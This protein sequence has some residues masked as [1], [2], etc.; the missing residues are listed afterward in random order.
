MTTWKRLAVFVSGAGIVTVFIT[1]GFIATGSV[2]AGQQNRAAAT[3]T[4]LD[5]IQMQQLVA[6]GQY[7]LHTG[8]DEGRLYAQLFTVDGTSGAVTGA[9]ALATYAKGGRPG[10]RSLVTNVIIEATPQGA[11]GRHYEFMIRFVKG[12]D[13]PVALD[14][15]GRYDDDF[16]KTSAG[17]RIKKRVFVPSVF[18]SEASKAIVP[19]APA[20]PAVRRP[21]VPAPMPLTRTP[22]DAF[23]STLT[24]LDYIQIQQL[25]AS[26]GQALDNGLDHEDNGEAYASLFAPGGVF[27]RPYTQGAEALKALARTQPHNRR[28]ARHFLTNI[29]IE[30]SPDGAAGRQYLVVIDQ[31]EGGRPSSALIAGH[32]EDIY[33]K[34]PEGWRFK[35]RT[36]FPARTGPQPPA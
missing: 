18:T 11:S 35:Q 27:G 9:G 28:Y 26:Y 5:Y 3:L 6:E 29:V 20:D 19:E 8:A 24:P 2:V 31:G 33:V 14:T 12:Q 32:Y 7:A 17:W 36:L 4:A 15:T 21:P 30:P 34:T 1:T 16:V 13:E 10:V 23:S 25:V 22:K